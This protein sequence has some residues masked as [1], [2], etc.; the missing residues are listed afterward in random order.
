MSGW[1]KKRIKRRR[2]KTKRRRWWRRKGGGGGKTASD[3][4]VILGTLPEDLKHQI[5]TSRK[6]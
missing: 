6:E 2:R 3:L 5:K 1:R 4:P